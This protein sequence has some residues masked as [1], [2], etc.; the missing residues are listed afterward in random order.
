MCTG[1]CGSGL[2]TVAHDSYAGA[3]VDGSAWTV[4]DCE[5]RVLRGGSWY[6]GPWLLRAAFRDWYSPG[7]RNYCFGG[8][9]V[10]R[11]LTS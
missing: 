10:A 7:N 2:R 5:A 9:R 6:D 8:F 4:G 1:M 3:P 11:T